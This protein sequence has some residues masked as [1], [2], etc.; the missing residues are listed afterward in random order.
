M[1]KTRLW[2]TSWFVRA[3]IRTDDVPGS[4]LNN[5]WV[6]SP[7]LLLVSSTISRISSLSSLLV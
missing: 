4:H 5:L 2:Q 6:L 1:L 7:L 3:V